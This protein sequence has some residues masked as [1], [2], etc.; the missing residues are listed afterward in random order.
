MI[1]LREANYTLRMEGRTIKKTVLLFMLICTVAASI[2]A[3]SADKEIDVVENIWNQGTVSR[4]TFEINDNLHIE[5]IQDGVYIVTHNFPWP[6]NSLAIEMNDSTVVL[7]D[8]PYTPD[9]TKELLKWMDKEFGTRKKVAI[10]THFH[11]DNLGG[12]QAL[13]EK[14]IAIYGSDL[15]AKLLSERGEEARKLTLSWLK[16]PKNEY[17]YNV[18]R[19]IPYIPPTNLFRLKEHTQL[20]FGDESIEIYYPGETHSPDCITVYFPNKKI[21]F[22]GCMIKSL[23]S[24]KL[25]NVSD[26]NLEAWPKSLN[27]VLESFQDAEIIIPGHGEWGNIDLITHTLNLLDKK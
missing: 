16:E 8:T 5:K 1:H 27:K 23:N 21:L 6:A 2:M 13:K 4:K 24:G 20:T 10:N 15:T 26:A 19:K 14:D 18:H 9:A 11:V 17:Y 25:G 12:N 3:C 22:G 7:V